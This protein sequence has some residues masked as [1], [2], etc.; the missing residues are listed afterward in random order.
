MYVISDLDRTI[1]A[2]WEGG[3]EPVPVPWLDRILSL[4]KVV[5]LITNQG[6]IAWRLAGGRPGKRYPDWPEVLTRIRAGMKWTG[7]TLAFAA[8]YHP[9]AP[10]PPLTDPV[11]QERGKEIGLPPVVLAAMSE[12]RLPV[13]QVVEEGVVFVSWSPDWRK[14]SPGAFRFAQMLLHIDP[15]QLC[16]VGDEDSDREAAE[17]AGIAFVDVRAWRQE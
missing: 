3:F 8:L 17:M 10:I 5:A 4:G 2:S 12:P 7:S 13:C 15:T 1:L 9:Q 11:L 6:G 14:P 16:Y